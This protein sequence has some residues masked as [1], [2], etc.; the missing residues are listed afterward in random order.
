MSPINLIWDIDGTLLDTHGLGVKPL[1][2]A[3]KLEYQNSL[4][5]IRG[6]Y[7]GFTDFEIIAD[8]SG[9]DIDSPFHHDGY[10]RVINTYQ[11]S[12]AKVFE[13]ASATPIGEVPN[14]LTELQ[15][16]SWIESYVGTGNYELT[17]WLKLQSAALDK[18]FT[19]ESVF[20]ANLN[21]MR[22]RDIIEHAKTTL[23]SR[24]IPII[25]GDSPADV[26]AAKINHVE[27]VGVP[28]GHHDFSTLNHLIPGRVLPQNW[29]LSDLLLMIEK[30]SGR[31][32]L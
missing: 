32:A 14:I 9:T 17:G 26:Y 27:I 31:N 7:S 24:G 10:F 8:L 19:S 22:R 15:K 5:L 18:F 25:I 23:D 6:K 28:T 12:L 1:E 13:R 20:G 29:E 2:N 30:I 11:K 3:V 16:Y 4:N 21:R